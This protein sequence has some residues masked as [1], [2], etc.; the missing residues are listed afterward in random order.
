MNKLGLVILLLVALSKKDYWGFHTVSTQ[1]Q[2]LLVCDVILDYEEVHANNCEQAKK[3]HF[4]IEME[5]PYSHYGY[6]NTVVAG[7]CP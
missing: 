4:M 6:V 3:P 5:K 2:A 1:T 7:C